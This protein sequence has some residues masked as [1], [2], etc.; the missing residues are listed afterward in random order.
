MS[1][2][3]RIQ[4]KIQEIIQ[5]VTPQT[6]Y[7]RQ[8]TRGSLLP[9]TSYQKLGKQ[10]EWRNATLDCRKC[11]IQRSFDISWQRAILNQTGNKTHTRE[12]SNGGG[13]SRGRIQMVRS[14]GV[15]CRLTS[16]RHVTPA[17]VTALLPRYFRCPASYLPHSR[18]AIVFITP[19]EW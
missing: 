10:L 3:G 6:S 9:E 12:K 5:Q 8:L 1:I 18:L 11:K 13:G 7:Q 14:K 17:H 4:R 2:R 19:V 15:T 16:S